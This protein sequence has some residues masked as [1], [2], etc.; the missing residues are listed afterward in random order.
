M[1]SVPQVGVADGVWPADRDDRSEAAVEGLHFLDWGGGG[2]G[3]GGVFV[4]RHVSAPCD[5]TN[6]T[7]DLHSLI[8][9]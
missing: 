5:R 6:L 8:F 9:E 4:S 3:G 2:G 1:C 7:V